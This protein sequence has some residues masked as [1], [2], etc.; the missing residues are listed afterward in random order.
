MRNTFRTIGSTD[1]QSESRYRAIFSTFN[2]YSS[3]LRSILSARYFHNIYYKQ[4][5]YILY[6]KNI[7]KRVNLRTKHLRFRFSYL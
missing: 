7:F 4:Y 2:A 1:Q 6:S 3:R 5:F